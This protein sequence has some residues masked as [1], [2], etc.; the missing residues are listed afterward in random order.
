[1]NIHLTALARSVDWCSSRP[2]R[3]LV[4]GAPGPEIWSLYVGNLLTGSYELVTDVNPPN[5]SGINFDDPRRGLDR[6]QPRHLLGQRRP[7]AR[8]AWPTHGSLAHNLYEWVEGQ[9]HLVG[10]IPT[11]G[12]SCTGAECTPAAAAEAGGR[13]PASRLVEHAISADGSRIVFSTG[14]E[15]I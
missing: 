5:E 6:L 14:D 4:A 8:S 11:S 2:N 10:L 1:M 13:N 9:L 3:P 12:T 7:D 15:A